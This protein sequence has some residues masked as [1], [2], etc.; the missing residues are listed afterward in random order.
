MRE[1]KRKSRIFSIVL[2]AVLIAAGLC[3]YR[4][5]MRYAYPLH[6]ERD[7]YAAAAEYALDPFLVMGVISAES[8]FAE[9][10]RSHKDAHGLMQLKE[11][12]AAWCV[13]QFD[14]AVDGDL[15]EPAVNI[16]IGC[17]YLR[18]LIDTFD[19]IEDTALAAYNA[20]QGN[21]RRWLSDT[22]YSKDGVTLDNIP[23][24]ETERYV[25]KV[26]SREGIYK[27]LYGNGEDIG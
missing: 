5:V 10:A 20:G 9:D 24:P 6:H 17:A 1:R 7:I 2:A 22:Q 11:D 13:E 18:Y 25:R 4:P 19:G 23:F 27:N 21:V 15:Y 26:R 12:T 8:R 14:I 16:R 3:C